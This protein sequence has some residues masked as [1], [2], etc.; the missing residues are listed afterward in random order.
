MKIIKPIVP[1][2]RIGK[3]VTMITKKAGALLVG[4]MNPTLH[5]EGLRVWVD[6]SGRVVSLRLTASAAR[7]YL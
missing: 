3:M 1:R 2:K 5:A 7:S 6:E 4:S